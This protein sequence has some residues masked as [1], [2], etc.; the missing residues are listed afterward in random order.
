MI[1]T[2]LICRC[3]NSTQRQSDLM[4]LDQVLSHVNKIFWLAPGQLDRPVL[5]EKEAV[6]LKAE[7]ERLHSPEQ[8]AEDI[9]V[10]QDI[11]RRHFPKDPKSKLRIAIMGLKSIPDAL[12]DDECVQVTP[13]LYGFIY[14]LLLAVREILGDATNGSTNAALPISVLKI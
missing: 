13:L 7:I 3:T 10:L 5:R 11:A 2:I 9:V 6:A 8:L 1:L 4:A 12:S 14:E